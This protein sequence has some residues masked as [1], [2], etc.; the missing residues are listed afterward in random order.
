VIVRVVINECVF[1]C[2]VMLAIVTV[3]LLANAE[4][5]GLE[6]FQQPLGN[7]EH[8]VVLAQFQERPRPA[9]VF[10]WRRAS[11]ADT[12]RVVPPWSDL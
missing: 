5:D 10:G 12:D 2:V 9:A 6:Q 1:V 8:R 4:S 7:R 11:A 3:F